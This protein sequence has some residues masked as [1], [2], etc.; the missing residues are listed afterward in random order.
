MMMGTRLGCLGIVLIGVN[1][2]LSSLAIGN[3]EPG[4]S[5]E[6][7]ILQ[8]DE[9]GDEVDPLGVPPLWNPMGPMQNPYSEEK[10]VLGKILFWDEQLSSDG[11][12][13]CGT[14]H[15]PAAGGAD[16]RD[17]RHP[18]FDL[19]LNTPD[20]VL[21]SLGVIQMDAAAQY[22]P[23]ATYRLDPQV[24]NR[25]SLSNLMSM[26]QGNLFW[27]GRAE[28]VFNDPESGQ[29]VFQSGV[30][31]LE[32][33]ATV[34]ILNSTE[35]GHAGRTWDQVRDKLAEVRPLALADTIPADML[36]A[37]L[38]DPSYGALFER[39]FGDPHISAVRIAYALATYQR[40]LV[41]DESPFDLY[42]E[43]DVNAMTMN[44]R[45]GFTLYQSSSCAS[46][47]LAPT[48]S[49]ALFFVDGVRPPGED[50]GRQAV[51]GLA[52]DRG[53]FRVPSLRNM[54]LR[55]RFMHTGGLADIDDVFDFY[56]HRNGLMPFQEGVHFLLRNPI[57][58]ST[59][60]ESAVKDF[61][62]NGLTDPRVAN[63]TY[64]FDRPGLYSERAVSNPAIVGSGELGSGGFVPVMIAIDP[65]NLGNADFKIGVDY[66]L[67]GAQAWVAVSLNPPVGGVVTSDEL[68][69]PI[70]LSGMG[71]GGGYGTLA[72]PIADN[73]LND[74]Q[75]L[76]MQWI[77]ADPGGGGGGGGGDGFVRSAVAQ[78]DLF[79]TQAAPCTIWCPADLNGDGVLNFV[80][81]SAFVSL[82]GNGN[83]MA[84]FNGDGVLN[85]VDV[86]AFVSAFGAGCP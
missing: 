72:Y 22:Q 3:D 30:G 21:G 10:R 49:S 36:A 32:I 26:F 69:G 39:A 57:L 77:I 7:V 14:C 65:P 1:S 66:A 63:E 47:H 45:A 19:I 52:S 15:I 86:S 55:N 74:G 5:F 11:T 81:V 42:I 70:A 46:C 6:E 59:A 71:N 61:L 67:G 38:V 27:D 40:T 9:V 73:S 8:I 35:M 79:C 62:L 56:G 25:V 85:F 68:Y 76:Y 54:S 44:Q 34:P 43:G 78:L 13:S 28:N 75:R 12:V 84:D 53:K 51:T 82:F 4:G 29:E 48:F 50:V 20:D 83:V 17:G 2:V 18:G 60:G 37:I 31:G 80:D 58:F 23:E 41:P 33:Q 16:P 64:P 24:T